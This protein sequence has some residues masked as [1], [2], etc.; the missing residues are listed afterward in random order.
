MM[1]G[2]IILDKNDPTE[3]GLVFND[4]S[5]SFF[6]H[7]EDHMVITN[8]QNKIDSRKENLSEYL[9]EGKA[10]LI[11]LENCDSIC[12][13]VYRSCYS[14]KTGSIQLNFTDY[15]SIEEADNKIYKFLN[16]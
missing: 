1:K 11:D 6:H 8:Y 4:G 12:Y 15:G 5:I 10:S 13:E 9:A 7:N 3:G 2:L 14:E 16:I